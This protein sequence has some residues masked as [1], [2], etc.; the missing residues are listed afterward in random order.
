[1]RDHILGPLDVGVLRDCLSDIVRR[2]EI[3]R[4]TYAFRDGQ[5]VQIIH[6]AEP[7]AL[8]VFDVGAESEPKEAAAR[9]LRAEMARVADLTQG[10]LARF[11]LVR[12]SENEHWLLR[13][14]HHILW[15]AWSA[16]LI[17]GELALL[18]S[19]KI[20]GAADQILEPEP[21]QVADYA[22]W[23]RKYF[24]PDGPLY[25]ETIAWWKNAIRSNSRRCPISHSSDR[26]RSPVSIA[27]RA[28]SPGPSILSS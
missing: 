6:P 19:A 17:F 4:T 28:G 10:P 12:F 20:D 2:H 25:Q 3:L 27:P 21:L 23:Q 24:R 1:M 13:I 15:D 18:Y 8:P 5:P 7:V 26:R 11:S 9:I 16:K 22:V 14:C